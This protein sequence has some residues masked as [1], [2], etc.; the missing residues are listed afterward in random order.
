MFPF[1]SP[2][3]PFS[4]GVQVGLTVELLVLVGSSQ[5]LIESTSHPLS[6]TFIYDHSKN[7]SISTYQT[8]MR[9]WMTLWSHS[10]FSQ[11]QILHTNRL[12]LPLPNDTPPNQILVGDGWT[13]LGVDSIEPKVFWRERERRIGRGDP[14][15]QE[16]NF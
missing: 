5:H 4:G 6:V 2:P 16:N 12:I 10:R 3:V 11:E 1:L 8:Q 13:A 7:G 14:G 9:F 15:E